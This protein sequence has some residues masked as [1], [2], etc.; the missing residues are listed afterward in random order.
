MKNLEKLKAIAVTGIFH[1]AII[2][3][4]TESEAMRIFQKYYNG[5]CIIN[6]KKKHI[7]SGAF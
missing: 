1:G 6:I 7:P 4:E 3:A 2:N 5:E